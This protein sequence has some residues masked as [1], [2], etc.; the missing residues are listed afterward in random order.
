MKRAAALLAL[1]LAA[2]VQAAQPDIYGTWLITEAR[3]APWAKAESAFDTAEQRRLIGSKLIYGKMRITGPRP[4]ACNR[5]RYRFLEAPP[6]Y[7]FQGGLTDP[8]AQ[9]VA[10]GFRLHTITTLETGCE[11]WIDFHF[12]DARTA[13]FGLN[14]MIYTLRKQ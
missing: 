10:L 12:V 13:L 3:A 1:V 2:P 4:L 8:A 9:A 6:D 7:L 14:N 5:P 11:G